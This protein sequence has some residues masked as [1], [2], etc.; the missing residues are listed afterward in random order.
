MEAFIYYFKPTGMGRDEMEDIF[1][2][3]LADLECEVTGAGGGESGGNLDLLFPTATDASP[4]VARLF[5]LFHEMNLA[6]GT[7][8]QVYS[9]VEEKEWIYP[10]P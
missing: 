4:I 8:V 5:A 1:M 3:K 9:D 10:G 7:V 6:P 2:E